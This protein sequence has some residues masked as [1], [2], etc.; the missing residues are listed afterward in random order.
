[1][2]PKKNDTQDINDELIMLRDRLVA[3]NVQNNELE[4]KFHEQLTETRLE[5]ENLIRDYHDAQRT[6]KEK[7]GLLLQMQNEIADLKRQMQNNQ[8]LGQNDN[9]MYTASR[10]PI[11]L[12]QTR[13]Q[14]E[15]PTPRRRFN[16]QG[17]R[18][19]VPLPGQ[20]LF[21]GKGPYECFIRPF[22]TLAQTCG[23]DDREKAFR[24]I[25]ALR[26]DAAD[27]VFNQLDSDEQNS[28]RALE[29]VLESRFKERR[30]TSSYLAELDNRRLMA[31]EKAVEY[32][33]DIK[34]LVR[35]AYPTADDL[36]LNTIN[37]R[38]FLK[39]IGDQQIALAIGMKE[40]RSIDEAGE[41]L[42]MYHSL[43]EESSKTQSPRVRV[44]KPDKKEPK[45]VTEAKFNDFR[46]EID[47]KFNEILSLIKDEKKQQ[48]ENNDRRFRKRDATNIECFKCHAFGHYANSCPT[49]GNG[50]DG[51]KPLKN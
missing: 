2:G 36:T 49:S 18:Y 28:F 47:E 20:M 23:W 7:D 14:C 6:N 8:P 34:K 12:E 33:M 15:S 42:E 24:L 35:K 51:N 48:P 5:R 43:K 17:A 37:I 3:A 30:S 32:V 16:N 29:H 46:K 22:K 40:P 19:D 26:G 27:F 4:N 44:V 1:M 13:I 9:V 11:D 50:N 39:G 31:R 38:H 45:Y 10:V 25:N 21:D 41:L